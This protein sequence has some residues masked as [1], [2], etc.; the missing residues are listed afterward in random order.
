M[1]AFPG[2]MRRVLATLEWFPLQRNGFYAVC[3]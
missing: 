1:T 2:E 3:K